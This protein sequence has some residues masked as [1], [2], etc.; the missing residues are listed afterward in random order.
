M[1]YKYSLKSL[2]GPLGDYFTKLHS[3]DLKY[4]TMVICRKR[5]CNKIQV[6]ETTSGQRN[7]KNEN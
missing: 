5:S 3:L 4:S 2:R 6:L 7:P 1:P